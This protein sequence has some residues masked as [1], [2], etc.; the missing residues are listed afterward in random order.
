M[1]PDLD[2]KRDSLTRWVAEVRG[3]VERIASE[4]ENEIGGPESHPPSGFPISP[5]LSAILERIVVEFDVHRVL[6]FGAGMSS[7]RFATA[8]ERQGG[9]T[10]VSVEQ[11]PSWCTEQ[12]A[13]VTAM[14]R[15]HSRMLIDT[16]SWCLDHNGIY[17]GF[18]SAASALRSEAPFDLILV[19]APQNYYGRDG[20][21]HIALPLVRRGS[22]VVL[23]DVH[24][25]T[26]RATLSRI[27]SSYSGLHLCWKDARPDGSRAA[28]MVSD[29][30][31][32][33]RFRIAPY[34]SGCLWAL[35]LAL[36]RSS[37]RLRG[38][39]H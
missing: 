13:A 16:P 37:R 27:L 22:F 19:D 3:K 12:W 26:E 7:V 34:V 8:L 9:G 15:V 39:R 2:E 31:T 18:R 33:R 35:W 38:M 5:M 30:S 36:R 21:L 20:S 1:V 10:L 32:A 24:R 17:M 28:M 11:D 29:G 23:D 4:V 6:E 25:I 14:P